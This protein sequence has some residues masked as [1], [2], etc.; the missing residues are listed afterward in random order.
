MQLAAA[1]LAD[2]LK[3]TAVADDQCRLVAEQLSRFL[4]GPYPSVWEEFIGYERL[5]AWLQ[6]QEKFCAEN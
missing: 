4:P 6:V 5:F 1:Q 2:A 3:E